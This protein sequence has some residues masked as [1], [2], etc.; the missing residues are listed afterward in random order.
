MGCLTWEDIPCCLLL[1]GS[2]RLLK[3]PISPEDIP[4]M[5][6][7]IRC[8]R[9]WIHTNLN[10]NVRIEDMASCIGMSLPSLRRH[11]RTA[12][13]MGL[14]QYKKPFADRPPATPFW[15]VPK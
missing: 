14:Q 13:G 3:L 10:K 1:C 4:I 15:R 7:L 8:A 9:N 11:V 2:P 6:P 5:G 12:T